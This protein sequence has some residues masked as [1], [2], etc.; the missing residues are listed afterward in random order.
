MLNLPTVLLH[1]HLHLHYTSYLKSHPKLDP[2]SYPNPDPNNLDTAAN[3]V[4]RFYLE[5]D[6]GARS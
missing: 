1:S 5:I 2:N 6:F 3:R 4:F